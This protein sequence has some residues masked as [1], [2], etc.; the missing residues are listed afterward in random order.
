VGRVGRVGR[1]GGGIVRLGMI[2]KDRLMM[3]DYMM[4]DRKIMEGR[5]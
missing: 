1:V 5:Q 2:M 3:S 4:I